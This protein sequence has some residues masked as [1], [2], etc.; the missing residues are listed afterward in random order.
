MLRRILN[1]SADDVM[2]LVGCL[3]HGGRGFAATPPGAPPTY[4][5]LHAALS[6]Q[7]PEIAWPPGDPVRACVP[8]EL[9]LLGT[10][11][12]FE[13]R[14]VAPARGEVDTLL[15]HHHGLGETR[16]T[17]LPRLLAA[18][19]P[20]RGR[21]DWIALKAVGHE[22]AAQ[23]AR[24]ISDR[25]RFMWAMAA[26]VAIAGR[27]AERLRARYRW[28]VFSGVSMGG[29]IA[30]G[31]AAFARPGYDAYVP[32]A[33]GPDLA[34]VLFRSALARGYQ[35]R[36][37]R[38]EERAPWRWHLDLA[39]PLAGGT[40]GA[41]IRPLLGRYDR[42]FRLEPQLRAYERIRR[43]RVAVVDR[44]HLT[45]PASVPLLARHIAAVLQELK[46]QAQAPP[47]E[48]AGQPAGALLG[49]AA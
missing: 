26:S 13:L 31:T 24:L 10:R 15:V 46:A 4:E 45:A 29:L 41:P 14:R 27:I 42:V 21:L 38:R 22:S 8:V 6:A 9:P 39:R 1:E 17:L 44:G 18:C 35:Q 37:R 5:E 32:I 2:V 36:F 28:I 34:D 33:A 25:T 7:P 19:P 16:H 23:V 48:H 3:L 30:L 20:L 40:G 47:R 43:A 11:T 12:C 49:S